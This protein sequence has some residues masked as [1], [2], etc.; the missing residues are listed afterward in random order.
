M[1]EPPTQAE[2][3]GEVPPHSSAAAP[4]ADQLPP[5]PPG[6]VPALDLRAG[7]TPARP[8][9]AQTATEG[10]AP[11][12]AAPLLALPSYEIL[13]ELGRGGMGVVFKARQVG[14]DRLVA[15]KM[16]LAG[17]LAGPDERARFR[18]EAEA[19][20]RLQH[21]NIVQI[22]EIGEHQGRPY[23]VLEFLDGGSLD[24]RLARTPQPAEAA[25]YLVQILARAMHAAH[26]RGIL[27]RDL[28]PAN[29]LLAA[30]GTPKITDFGLAKR[31]DT[32]GAQGEDGRTQTGAIVGTPNY[33]A[34]EQ[35]YGLSA[36]V[37]PEA[38]T[39]ALG[40]ILYECLTGGPPFRGTTVWETLDLVRTADPV[41]PRRLQP[42]VPR[43][44][45]TVTLKCLEK[46]P[47]KRYPSAEALAEDLGH[48]L[49]G[50]P[51]VARPVSLAG[52]LVKWARRRP[53]VAAG[54]GLF[55][56][57]LVVGFVVI[58]WQ[59]YET[60]QARQGEERQRL[61]AVAKGLL[62]VKSAEDAR[63][64][65]KEAEHEKA[66]AVEARRERESQLYL[67]NIP[68]AH[69]EWL[70]GNVGR[71]VQLVNECPPELRG[72]EWH[73]LKR[74]LGSGL[75]T[76]VGQA[77][78]ISSLAYSPDGKLLATACPSDRTVYVWDAEA[79][80]L[81]RSLRGHA[82]AV[83]AVAFTPDGKQ[84]VSAG[85]DRTVRF[86][87]AATGKP[88]LG[89]RCPF[90]VTALA[91][92][93]DGKRLVL[94][95]ADGVVRLWDRAEKKE[96]SF[97][98]HAGPIRSVAINPAGTRVA[99]TST[100]VL[101]ES[102]TRTVRLWDAATGAEAI[103]LQSEDAVGQA[104]AVA[105]SPDGGQL[106]VANLDGKIR[107]YDPRSGRTVSGGI[108][109]G[110]GHGVLA[111]AYNRDGSRL[112]SAGLDQLVKVWDV[113]TRR[114]LF[115]LRGH[116]MPVKAVAFRPDGRRLASGDMYGVVKVWDA[117][118]GQDALTVV[119]PLGFPQCSGV[120]FRADGKQLVTTRP[121]WVKLW[122]VAGRRAGRSFAAPNAEAAAVALSPDGRS[123]AAAYPDGRVRLW[124]TAAGSEPRVLDGAAGKRHALFVNPGTVLAFRADSRRLVWADTR[125]QA[126]VWDVASGK[127]LSR[128][129][130]KDAVSVAL[131]PDAR[132]LAWGDVRGNVTVWDPASGRRLQTVAGPAM[133]VTALALDPSGR[134][135]AADHDQVRI[136]DLQTGRQVQALTGHSARGFYL[137]FSPDGRRLASASFDRSVRL[138]DVAS[139]RALLSLRGHLAPRPGLAFSPDGNL[140]AAAGHDGLRI[141]DATPGRETV[142]QPQRDAAYGV[143]LSPDGRHVA[144]TD[145]ANVLVWVRASGRPVHHLP[146][147][148]RGAGPPGSPGGT[149]IAVAFSPDGKTL[150]A[151]GGHAAGRG[152]VEFWDAATGE[153]L[154]ALTGHTASAP[155]LAFSPDGRRLATA[156]LDGTAKVWDVATGKELCAFKRH[157]GHVT[158]VA[159]HPDGRRV[160]SGGRDGVVRV[161]D[162]ET[163]S[164]SRAL[165]G[166]DGA[167]RALAFSLDGAHLAAAV[168]P[169]EPEKNGEVIVWDV[170]GRRKAVTFRGHTGGVNAVAYSPDGRR[171]VSAG[172]DRVLR[173]WDSASGRE[174][175]ALPGHY[176]TVIRL[177]LGRDG[178]FV[179]SA[180]LDRT[181]RVW[182]VTE[183]VGKHGSGPNERVSSMAPR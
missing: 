53:A 97:R 104:S 144:C 55:F 32:E 78:D 94:G 131:D 23:F 59:L 51:I 121:G 155:D 13:E 58:T 68:L 145:V 164:E 49:A 85:L 80:T 18:R 182:D 90:G 175:L 2:G 3:P 36:Q 6:S 21:P 168:V 135:L 20:A 75:L 92:A 39:Y 9:G 112:V 136:W 14:L 42:K 127:E 95:G 124:D 15:V 76:L 4:S 147:K 1:P 123:V 45:E 88:G 143:A 142:L 148:H 5:L 64:A 108:L 101:G 180:S 17:S 47:R 66:A 151:S 60:E 70:A 173:L 177:A 120:A 157:R 117:A 27:H 141:W 128:L 176:N 156:S 98:G 160:A 34:P 174:L 169:K 139:G 132:R 154:R 89:R 159:Y 52:R 41:P 44:L 102:A 99:S 106:V 150:A 172:S 181:V 74:Q 12:S 171:L 119:F 79:G 122:D 84:L 153:P 61:E 163:G 46:D 165:R 28:K 19:V 16:I 162:A 57:A 72:W 50:E 69:A 29:V 25:A 133:P 129:E 138:W 179:V 130:D 43:D 110:H 137:A 48:F 30:D 152:A 71:A 93:A 161:W 114:E 125:G 113:P 81:L 56:L 126:R 115:T 91:V 118:G 105:F 140:L 22:H 10:E 67:S 86:W 83:T 166:H 82:D 116:D 109:T 87:D 73:Y 63:R 111:V 149:A 134:Y 178:R 158:A 77:T 146:W 24:T 8:A 96:L 37:G 100:I 31:L 35:A 183:P 107:I 40:A 26:E 65:Q 11:Q 33:M 103:K 54:F 167:V 170:A 62:A 38:D 7:S